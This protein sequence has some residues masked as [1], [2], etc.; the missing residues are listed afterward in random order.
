MVSVETK[1]LLDG[2]FTRLFKD[3]YVKCSSKPLSNMLNYPVELKT[4]LDVLYG[5]CG[6]GYTFGK[7][8]FNISCVET[9]DSHDE[10]VVCAFS[11]GKDSLANV[12]LLKSLGY[13]PILFFVKGINRSYPKEYETS[14][15][16]AEVLG[17]EIVTYTLKVSGKCDFVENPVK[18]QFI[19]ALMVDY[20]LKLGIP[21]YSF[22]A[23]RGDTVD[24]MSSDYMLSDAYEMF[25]S[26]ELF[27]QHFMPE[28]NL[29]NFLSTE[30]ES[31][32]HI[33]N[34]DKNLLEYTYSCMTPLRYKQNL[35]NGAIKKYGVELL[36]NRCP[37]CHK[38]CIEAITL[39]AMGVKPYPEDFIKHCYDVLDRLDKKQSATIS[40]NK[41]ADD[42]D[43]VD[44]SYISKYRKEHGLDVY[45][46]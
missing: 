17:M 5:A 35:I 2:Q 14:L 1:G 45:K 28:F 26:I 43:W 4:Y 36:P 30:T 46:V 40:D 20:G 41:K 19:L 18:N 13:K 25:V 3:L 27:Y 11:G 42:G 22:G 21:N 24:I 39:N 31:F 34:Y 7:N 8:H 12:L 15:K 9:F 16:L 37:S 33:C 29:V 6:Y 38:C 10:R 32:Y 23:F 44:F